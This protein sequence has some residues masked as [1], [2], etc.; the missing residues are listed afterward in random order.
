MND[1]GSEKLPPEP[2]T[3][4]IEQN[5]LFGLFP[6]YDMGDSEDV[7]MRS[8]KQPISVNVNPLK[9]AGLQ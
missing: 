4:N 6:Q 5:Q 9:V 7:T 8:G 3:I 2:K 1:L